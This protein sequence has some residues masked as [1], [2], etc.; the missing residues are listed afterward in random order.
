M[1]VFKAGLVAL[2]SLVLAGAAS[3]QGWTVRTDFT[4]GWFFAGAGIEGGPISFNCA[5][6]Y[7][8]ADWSYGEGGGPYDPYIFQ[9]S[10]IEWN[11][12]VLLILLFVMIEQ[13]A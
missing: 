10:M 13:C 2:A 7:P 1:G 6:H 12:I 4:E 8:G 11:V 5:D 9:I 3:A